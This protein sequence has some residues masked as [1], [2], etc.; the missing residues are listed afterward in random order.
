MT[1]GRERQGWH[2]RRRLCAPDNVGQ[3]FFG[4]APDV[5]F[6]VVRRLSLFS[7]SPR[8]RGPRASVGWPSTGSPLSRGRRSD[9]RQRSQLV[10]FRPSSSRTLRLAQDRLD[11]ESTAALTSWIPDRVRGDDEK[12]TGPLR[13]RC[14]ARRISP[15][16]RAG[17]RGRDS[18]PDRRYC[19]ARYGPGMR[20]AADRSPRRRR[21]SRR[22]PVQSW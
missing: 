17:R 2:G 18:P 21:R 11:P 1:I 9:D 13:S 4:L 3:R 22:Q 5:R 12:G 19:R 14:R 6:G 10:V 20:R 16:T 8:K 7:S 15:R